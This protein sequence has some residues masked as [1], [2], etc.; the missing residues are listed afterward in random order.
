MCDYYETLY[1]SFKTHKEAIHEGVKYMCSMF[2]YHL[3]T[4][5]VNLKKNK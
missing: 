3:K 2:D 5:K 1:S 4:D